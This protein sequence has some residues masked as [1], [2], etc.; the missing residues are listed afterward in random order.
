MDAVAGYV[1]EHAPDL[2]TKEFD[3]EGV[4]LHAT[5]MNSRFP[6]AVV[7]DAVK[8]EGKGGVDGNWRKRDNEPQTKIPPRQAFNAAKIFKVRMH[9]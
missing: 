3:R 7:K 4:K 1:I 9:L 2:M 6:V 8:R 5:L